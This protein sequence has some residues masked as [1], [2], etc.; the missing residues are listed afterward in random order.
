[1][2][3]RPDVSFESV[4][5]STAR[6]ISFE[7]EQF[8][9]NVGNGYRADLTAWPWKV[10]FRSL[11]AAGGSMKATVKAAAGWQAS[12]L[13]VER[14]VVYEVVTDGTWRTAP[15]GAPRDADGDADGRRVAG[16]RKGWCRDRAIG[17]GRHDS[18]GHTA[19]L[20]RHRR[21]PALPAVRG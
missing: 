6:E 12:G 3:G 20:R 5:G 19:G 2:E 10:K 14:G 18:T 7:Y 11:P 17:A 9:R 13:R 16:G 8:L 1:M 4:Y 15:A 21:R